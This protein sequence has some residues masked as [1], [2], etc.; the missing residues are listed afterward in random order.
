MS[1]SSL[2]SFKKISPH[3]TKNRKH[4][5]DSVAI[6]CMA[7]NMSVQGCGDW[8]SN[9]KSKASSNYGVDSKGRIGM[10]VEEKDRAWTTCSGGVDN[11]AITIEVANT[12]KKEPYPI[13]DKAYEALINLLVDICRRNNIP[14]LKWMGDKAY[15]KRA[16]NGGPVTDQNMFVHR[17]FSS[18]SCP[19]KWLYDHHGEIANEV[20]RRLGANVPL[21]GVVDPRDVVD[22]TDNTSTSATNTSASSTSLTPGLSGINLNV[23]EFNPYVVTID[24]NTKLKDFSSLKNYGVVGGM[25]EAGY[26]YDALHKPVKSYNNPNIS[27]QVQAFKDAQLPFGLF[28]TCRAY[29]T[30]EARNELKKLELLVRLYSPQLGVWII[31]DTTKNTKNVNDNLVT[32]YRDWLITL[33][34]K[35]R[36]GMYLN[37]S[38]LNSMNWSKHQEDWL[39]WYVD[40]V[41]STSSI[42]EL[43]NPEFFDMEGKYT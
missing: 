31:F 26:L 5:I 22:R 38:Q 20:N 1:N 10:Y 37:R 35:K 39:L 23:E 42:P 43:L 6:H 33:G 28:A 25:I 19:G 18:K 15:A 34:L 2:V 4:K 13:S 41:T 16:A 17:W 11:R 7:G 36:M 40:H 21:Q 3:K 30:Q 27:S 12:S 32:F 9:K 29:T 14:A 24:R 8:F